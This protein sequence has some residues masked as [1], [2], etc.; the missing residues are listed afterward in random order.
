MVS[1]AITDAPLDSGYIE[2]YST[3]YAFAAR[4]AKAYL[5]E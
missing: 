1:G 3:K 5:V 4:A 2:I